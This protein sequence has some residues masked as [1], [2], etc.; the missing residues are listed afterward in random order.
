MSRN[1]ILVLAFL[2]SSG[3]PGFEI[4]VGHKLS[5][6]GVNY[7]MLILQLL[8]SEMDLEAGAHGQQP[9]IFRER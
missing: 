8:V 7:L 9:E 6:R 3:Q 1:A 2:A 4:F 5:C